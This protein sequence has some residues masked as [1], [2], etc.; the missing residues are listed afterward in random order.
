MIKRILRVAAALAIVIATMGCSAGTSPASS[1]APTAA[2]ASLPPG[3]PI[4]SWATTITADDLRA[5]GLT[6]AAAI[7]ENAGVFRLQMA[8]DGTWTTTQVTDVPVK[9]PIFRGTRIATGPETFRQTTVFPADFA[10]D[11]V[12]FTWRV[13]DG[14]LHLELP[15]P[16]DPV[17]PV[18]MESHPWTPVP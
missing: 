6:D 3:F 4:G 7:G 10:D 15:D 13:Q 12:D 18:I 14:T 11:V 5:A 8:D 1:T 2:G 17:L 9:W 16:P